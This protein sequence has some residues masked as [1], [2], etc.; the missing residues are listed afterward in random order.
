MCPRQSCYTMR[1]KKGLNWRNKSCC[2]RLQQEN[3]TKDFSLVG[4]LLLPQNDAEHIFCKKI[5]FCSR[6]LR[7]IV[8]RV[9]FVCNRLVFCNSIL[10]FFCVDTLFKQ[11]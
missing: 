11:L 10:F 4:L 3:P 1:W 5:V 8:F 6:Y 7:L 9:Q 2:I